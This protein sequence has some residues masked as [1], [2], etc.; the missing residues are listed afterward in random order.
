RNVIAL[1]IGFENP[2][3]E[4]RRRKL[5]LCRARR[6]LRDHSDLFDIT[7]AEFQSL[8]R[9][10]QHVMVVLCSVAFYASGSYQRPLGQDVNHNLGQ[11]TVS[12]AVKEVTDI[13]NHPD[14]LITF[15]RFPDTAEERN[16]MIQRYVYCQCTLR[17]VDGTLV[18]IVP[19]PR[20]NQ[21]YRSRKGF[22]A[23]NVLLVCNVSLEI[24]YCNARFPG[25]STDPYIY[26]NSPLRDA[27]RDAYRESN[28]CVL[29]DS[30]FPHEPWLMGPL[31]LAPR[32]TPEYSYT[33]LHMKCRN[34]VERCIGVLKNRFR[35]LLWDRTL[36]CRPGKAGKIVNA[37]VVV[38]N[39]LVAR[40][41]VNPPP[42]FEGL[43]NDAPEPDYDLDAPLNAE[44][45]AMRAAC[46]TY[47]T[48]P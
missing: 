1:H 4:H 7:T 34:V 16:A 5:E 14:V 17:Y 44:A 29:G 24:I 48:C 10:P 12:K 37:C 33:K 3:E 20:P 38:H 15:I 45:D 46:S 18:N 21:H 35:C 19:P 25:S 36:H 43:G 26:R 13:F 41:I 47:G 11:G 40:R 42:V 31:S 32:G 39:F 9:M 8:Y 28:C 23:L 30:G 6:R 22:A 27:L 2:A